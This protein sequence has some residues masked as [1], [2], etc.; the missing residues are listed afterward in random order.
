M[1][2]KE[3]WT[4]EFPPE[5][6]ALFREEGLE[7]A[8]IAPAE[9]APESAEEYGRWIAEG[10]HGSMGYLA[11][12]APMKFHPDTLLPGCRSIIVAALN[13]Y[14]EAS[15]RRADNLAAPARGRA[16]NAPQYAPADRDSADEPAPLGPSNDPASRPAAGR[17]GHSNHA[18]AGRIARYAW[19]RD[20]HKVLGKR[21][22]R[23]VRK[24]GEQFPGE[25]FRSFT[26]AVP[27]AERYYAERAAI[28]FTAKNTLSISSDFG[29]WFLIGEILSTKHFP[30]SEDARDRHG[31]CPTNCTRCIDICPT[32]ALYAPHR[33]DASKCISY[34]TI[35]HK[36]EIPVELRPKMGNWLFGCD[37]CQE[38]C[39]LN[40]RAQQT[41]VSDFLTVKAGES[42]ELR[43]VLEIE[44]DD[45]YTRRFAGSPLMRAKRRGLLRNACIAAA[46]TGAREILPLLRRRAADADPI[47]ASHAQWAV[48]QLEGGGGE[49]A[50]G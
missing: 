5:L 3:G 40:V 15:W 20:Y 12:H 10:K 7:V 41:G 21:L 48:E 13:Y 30:S 34:L 28:A 6:V 46:N 36:G 37:L 32:G 11:E 26:D 47:I 4:P 23:I 35:E 25:S 18:T 31:A 14:Q 44:N 19:G 42:L 49:T 16:S 9:P 1:I 50:D 39:P 24:L 8:G 33:I 29:S 17:I 38:V 2:P 43:E 45:E 22:R 27:L